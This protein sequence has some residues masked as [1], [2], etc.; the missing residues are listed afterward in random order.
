MLEIDG[1]KGEGG[2]Q[3]LRTS[4]AFGC[5]M[6]EPIR[7]Y[8]IRKNR[9]NPGLA[10]QHLSGLMAVARICRGRVEKGSLGSQEI[11]FYPGELE[12]GEFNFDMGT[13]GSISLFLQA[14][15]LPS[16]FSGKGVSCTIS[17]GT[18]VRWSPPMDFV[19]WILAPTIRRMGA[20]VHMDLIERGFYPKGGG[21]VHFRLDRSK[22]LEALDL[23]SRGKFKSI[24]GIAHCQNLP[25]H[26]PERERIG[27]LEVLKDYSPE[28][29]IQ[30]TNG[31]SPGTGIT[32]WAEFGKS[33]MGASSLGEIGKPAEK[34]GREA[35]ENLLKEMETGATGDIYL[36]DQI[37]P[38]MALAKGT[39]RMLV[40]KISGHIETN[41]EIIEYFLGKRF[42]IKNQV[43]LYLIECTG[44]GLVKE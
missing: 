5:I 16:I 26:I 29:E 17:G 38:F 9:K 6:Q 44:V 24:K 35:A 34:V 22:G 3:I 1:S 43:G 7:I 10:T 30:V 27:A 31:L 13:A 37:L 23:S 33:V 11:I 19:R 8:N 25:A 40:R 32:L 41:I 12:G 14:I 20:G 15:L 18:D 2:G 36:A 28:I 39:S 42:E 21:R 4:L